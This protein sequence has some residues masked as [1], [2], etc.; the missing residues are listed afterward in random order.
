MEGGGDDT[1]YEAASRGVLFF[2]LCAAH[3]RPRSRVRSP[4]TRSLFC[5]SSFFLSTCASVI[6]S[7]LYAQR[8][9]VPTSFSLERWVN[10]NY[11]YIPFIPSFTPLPAPSES[12][13]WRTAFSVN[14]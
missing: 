12:I 7:P 10:I 5:A 3:F 9:I 8:I 4:L 11:L 1:R 2:G 14:R 6:L 13:I